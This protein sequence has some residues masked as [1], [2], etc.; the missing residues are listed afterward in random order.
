[1]RTTRDR[2]GDLMPPLPCTHCRDLFPMEI[3]AWDGKLC[4]CR[5]QCDAERAEALIRCT[6]CGTT[7]SVTYA[8]EGSLVALD[9]WYGGEA[10]FQWHCQIWNGG[11]DGMSILL[12]DDLVTADNQWLADIGDL[13]ENDAYKFPSPED[14]A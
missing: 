4:D 2:T 6:R 5:P 13:L 12:P 10:P 8:D 3:M 7:F 1:M 11:A 14:Q 9:E